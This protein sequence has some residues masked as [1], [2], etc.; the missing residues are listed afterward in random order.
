MSAATRAAQFCS[1]ANRH[2]VLNEDQEPMTEQ[3]ALQAIE[4]VCEREAEED[5]RYPNLSS[6]VTWHWIESLVLD[7]F[8][9]DADAFEGV[10]T[11]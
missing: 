8:G 11:V 5:G 4:A 6:P 7:R 2:G 1:A 3:D 10:V 9:Y